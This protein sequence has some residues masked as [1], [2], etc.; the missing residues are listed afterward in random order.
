VS[1]YRAYNSLLDTAELS[2]LNL[3]TMEVKSFCDVR[4]IEVKLY[5]NSSV[6]KLFFFCVCTTVRATQT[7]RLYLFMFTKKN[8]DILF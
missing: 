1:K 4:D 7:K 6:Q 8:S 5:F 2:T 3:S